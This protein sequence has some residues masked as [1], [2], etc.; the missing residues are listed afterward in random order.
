MEP[1]LLV[2]T[3]LTSTWG[4]AALSHPRELLKSWEEEQFWITPQRGRGGNGGTDRGLIWVGPLCP[5][6]QQEGDQ[7]QGAECRLRLD[8][9]S[10][11][12]G[13]A[14]ETVS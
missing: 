2:I 7:G 11:S 14:A 8:G 12:S 1:G 6:R 13:R 9:V 4:A 5:A 10:G 3:L